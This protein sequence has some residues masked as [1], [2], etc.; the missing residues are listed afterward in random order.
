[1][2]SPKEPGNPTNHMCM[3]SPGP[4]S[5][6]DSDLKAEREPHCSGGDK[7]DSRHTPP[8]LLWA[9]VSLSRGRGVPLPLNLV[10]QQKK[11][12]QKPF[13]LWGEQDTRSTYRE[14]V[15]NNPKLNANARAEPLALTWRP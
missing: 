11:G 6:Q 13:R 4:Q 15:P 2:T 8:P 7:G 14:S 10:D 9:P 3:P 12:L 5:H 1:M